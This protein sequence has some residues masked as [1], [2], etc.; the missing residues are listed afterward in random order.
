MIT[1]EIQK[2]IDE[3]MEKLSPEQQLELLKTVNE[4]VKDMNKAFDEYFDSNKDTRE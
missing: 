1:Q 4:S 2:K 3:V